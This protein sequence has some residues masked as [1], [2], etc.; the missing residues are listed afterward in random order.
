METPEK[1]QRVFTRWFGQLRPMEYK[2]K[3]KAH[4]FYSTESHRESDGLTMAC[5]IVKGLAEARV[6]VI[7]YCR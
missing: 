3:L 7:P 6:T 1:F 4:D 5:K 2:Q